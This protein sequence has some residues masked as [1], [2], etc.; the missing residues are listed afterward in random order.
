M[1]VSTPT[2]KKLEGMFLSTIKQYHADLLIHDRDTLA[3]NPDMPFFFCVHS[4]GT[5]LGLFYKRPDWTKENHLTHYFAYKNYFK[6][7][8][9]VSPDGI[10]VKEVDFEALETFII[11]Q[12]DKLFPIDA[13]TPP[14]PIKIDYDTPLEY[15]FELDSQTDGED[16]IATAQDHEMPHVYDELAD[17]ITL[18]GTVGKIIRYYGITIKHLHQS[19][20]NDTEKYPNAYEDLYSIES[21]IKRSEQA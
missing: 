17:S 16:I 2:Y 21:Y 8:F 7:R 15:K 11:E 18:K 3:E 6:E 10:I 12:V 9:A 13:W 20:F 5:H 14:D 4:H 19:Y 1:N